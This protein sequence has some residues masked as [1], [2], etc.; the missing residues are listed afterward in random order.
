MKRVRIQS[1]HGILIPGANSSRRAMW[2]SRQQTIT[3][4][5]AALVL[6][7]L[8]CTTRNLLREA[9]LL[10]LAQD[11]LDEQ[12]PPFVYETT[13]GALP[14]VTTDETCPDY[15][16][17][18]AQKH[19]PEANTGGLFDLPL[20]RPA[21]RCRKV[22]VPEVEAV[23]REMKQ[24]IKD[25]DLSR[26]FENT[27]PNTLDTSITWTGMSG[28][29][30][31][32]E[33]T[34]ITTGDIHAMWLR[35]SANQLQSYVSLLKP[36]AAPKDAVSAPTGP[37]PP[38]LA[39]LFRGAINLQSRYIIASP[40]CNAFQPPTEAD[41]PPGNDGNPRDRVFP[42]YDHA[43]VFEC[44]YELD[45]LAAFL[46]LSWDYFSHTRDAR[47]F[48]DASTAS[49]AAALRKTKLGDGTTR[50]ARR[51]ARRGRHDTWKDAVETILDVADAMRQP[52]YRADGM[53]PDSPYRFERVSSAATE[54]LPNR[55]NGSPVRD[56]TGLVRSAFRPSDDATTYQLL[57][58]ANM[59]LANYLERC[60]EIMAKVEKEEERM[61]TVAAATQAAGGAALA[62]AARAGSQEVL[63][64]GDDEAGREQWQEEDEEWWE[65]WDGESLTDRM[66]RVTKEI[67]KGIDKYAK[68]KH[69]D[70]GEMYAYEVDGYQSTNMM[71]SFFVMT[72]PLVTLTEHRP[73]RRQ[74][75]LPPLLPAHGLPQAHRRRLPGHPQVR[76]LHRQ[77]VLRPRRR[78]QRD[79]R[80]PHRPGHGLAHVAGRR[81]HDDR[82]RRRDQGYALPAARLDRRAGP[83]PRERQR[84][85]RAHVDALVVLV[86]QR[87]VWADD[88]GPEGAEAALAQDEL[89]GLQHP[90]GPEVQLV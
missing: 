75:P 82:R 87:P 27:F 52:T 11:F 44:K 15:G 25:P 14:T 89:P 84:A 68:V 46:Q 73:G 66:R 17:F 4:L 59:M 42:P 65:E 56:G 43:V 81:H 12:P 63:R 29:N 19:E 50:V 6:Y 86:G 23:I 16:F 77:P 2:R 37:S 72:S 54:T 3:Y 47:F 33:L 41:M 61:M 83:D 24:L 40:F 36:A 78:H 85:Q 90:V 60:A 45:S 70:F 53:V 62:A 34:F 5:A 69:P 55:G 9:D 26:L 48:V 79:G 22:V 80:P 35:D 10:P 67:R 38:K 13:L 49:F 39:S 51:R 76:S 57:V 32:R 28:S 20:Q 58:P 64:G 8:V 18:A 74:P 30:A 71:V 21:E 7:G 1:A 88:A 31:N